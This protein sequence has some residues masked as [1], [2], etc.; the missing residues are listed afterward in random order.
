[1]FRRSGSV[2]S[3]FVDGK[4]PDPGSEAFVSALQNHRFRTIENA[5]SEESSVGWVSPG[6]PTGS[7]FE[8][9]DLDL[10][11]AVWLRMRIDQKKLPSAWVAIHRAEAERSA[12]RKL[13]V[14]ER[15]DLKQSLM[16]SLL[17]RVLPSVRLIDALWAPKAGLVMLF[18]T[19][20][21][22][23]EEFSKL[24]FRTFAVNLAEADPYGL[25]TR[26]GLDR[27]AQ[28]YL[29][30]VSPVPWPGEDTRR[31]SRSRPAPIEI[32]VDSDESVT[33]ADR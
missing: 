27:E 7:S 9:E 20:K 29:D 1:M 4:M 16:D 22:V 6:D 5:A 17:P 12:G 2:V 23:R 18:G 28:A 32:E 10:D 14:R 26:V 11:L 8:R 33:E 19:A 31:G 15:R 3:W 24:F 25:A 21:S 13:S 30:E